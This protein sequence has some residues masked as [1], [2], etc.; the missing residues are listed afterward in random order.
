MAVIDWEGEG[1]QILPL[2]F[3]AH[4]PDDVL[5]TGDDLCDVIYSVGNVFRN[6]IYGAN[7]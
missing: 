2:I 7:V 5:S 1:A 3:T 4:F 6:V